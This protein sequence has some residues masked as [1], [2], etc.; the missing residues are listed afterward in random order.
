MSFLQTRAVTQHVT[1]TARVEKQGRYD[2]HSVSIID[3]AEK[4]EKQIK[5]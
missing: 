2:T 3:T 5:I 4:P 1:I